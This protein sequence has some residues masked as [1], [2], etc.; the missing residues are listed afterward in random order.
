MTN[1]VKHPLLI[2][3]AYVAAS[4]T[5]ISSHWYYLW[6]LKRMPVAT[7]PDFYRELLGFELPGILR[8]LIVDLGGWGAHLYISIGQ[9]TFNLIGIALLVFIVVYKLVR[10]VRPDFSP[11]KAMIVTALV[12]V[13]IYAIVVVGGILGTLGLLRHVNRNYTVG[14]GFRF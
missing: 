6:W 4:A 7:I 2:V 10:R 8:T 9:Q 12:P 13:A 3:L 14:V 1:L 5:V 11:L